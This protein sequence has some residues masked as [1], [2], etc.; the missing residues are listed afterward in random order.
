LLALLATLLESYDA[1]RTAYHLAALDQART[2]SALFNSQMQSG[3]SRSP[4]GRSN[5]ESSRSAGSSTKSCNGDFA[6]VAG[7]SGALANDELELGQRLW[8]RAE[9]VDVI[10]DDVADALDE[11]RECAGEYRTGDSMTAMSPSRPLLV[12]NLGNEKER[13]LLML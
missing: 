10:G 13:V 4:D 3:S 1:R 8:L 5:S 6:T 9:K 2:K 12:D 11:L 7:D